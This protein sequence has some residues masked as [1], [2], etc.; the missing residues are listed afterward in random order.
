MEKDFKINI[1]V[2]LKEIFWH[3]NKNDIL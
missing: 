3:K 2:T 1:V